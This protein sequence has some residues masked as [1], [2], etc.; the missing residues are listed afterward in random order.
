MLRGYTFITLVGRREEGGIGA[1]GCSQPCPKHKL[2]N[3]EIPTVNTVTKN[4]QQNG[5]K[6]AKMVLNVQNMSTMVNKFHIWVPKT[7][8]VIPTPNKMTKKGQN[9]PRKWARM[10]HNGLK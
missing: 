5:L 10:A 3:V 4:S 1:L 8:Q 6:W 7:I 2:Q 9:L